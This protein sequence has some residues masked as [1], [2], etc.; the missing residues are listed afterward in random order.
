MLCMYAYVSVQLPG[1]QSS[2]TGVRSSLLQILL[3][4]RNSDRTS[5]KLLAM[6]L[7][8]H[9][10]VSMCSFLQITDNTNFVI[11]FFKVLFKAQEFQL[12][13]PERQEN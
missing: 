8:T 13:K 2:S 9:T 10:E 6:T 12:L 7:D 5:E 11:S 3:E 4:E 1:K